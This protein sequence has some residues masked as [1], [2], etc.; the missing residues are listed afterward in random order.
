MRSR[1]LYKTPKK[2]KIKRSKPKPKPTEPVLKVH[3]G[4]LEAIAA[5]Y[6]ANRTT[7]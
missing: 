2:R 4:W 3:F 6:Q 5:R 7:K 1:I